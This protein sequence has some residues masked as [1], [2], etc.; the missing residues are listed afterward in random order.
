MQVDQLP[1]A[2]VSN[3]LRVLPAMTATG[4]NYRP[5]GSVHDG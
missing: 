5:E 3:A 1:L 4:L 2:Y